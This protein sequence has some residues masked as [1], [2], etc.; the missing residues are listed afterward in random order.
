MTLFPWT[1]SDT[2]KA[3]Q[4]WLEN[5]KQHDLS[6]S[7]GKTAGID[8]N[9]GC[10]WIGESIQDVLSQRDADKIESLIVLRTHRFKNL[11]SQ[12]RSKVIAGKVSED[13]LDIPLSKA[14]FSSIRA[15]CQQNRIDLLY[16]SKK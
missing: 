12:R 8:P 9:T 2:A 15:K 10:V 16:H 6:T 5:Q 4:I 7:I 3:E 11:L 14:L 1:E 13:G